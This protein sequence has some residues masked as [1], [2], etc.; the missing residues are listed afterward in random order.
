MKNHGGC[1]PAGPRIL[2]AERIDAPQPR[3]YAL[4]VRRVILLIATGFGSGYVPAL[5]GTA[6]SVV[7]GA[8]YVALSPLPPAAYAV[9]L[10]GALFL[11]VWAADRAE[12]FFEERDCQRIVIDE[13]L[14]M[15][16]TLAFLPPTA[17]NV[18][19]G[20]LFF[21]VF[22]AFKPFP[23]GRINRGMYGGWGVVLDDVAA[24]VYAAI[25]LRI[26]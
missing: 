18:G 22:D 19:L 12:D 9:T 7:G 16:I 13:V 3:G 24:G 21:R 4:G 1:P 20:F 10:L 17:R 23:A 2:G 14:G 26:L 8:L 25:L 5:R 6:G 11:S 15:L